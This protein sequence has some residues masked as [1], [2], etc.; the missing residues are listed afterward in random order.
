[1]RRPV[2]PE[3]MEQ[4]SRVP[5]RKP[6]KRLTEHAY[7]SS[8]EANTLDV[9]FGFQNFFRIFSRQHSTNVGILPTQLPVGRP[10]RQNSANGSGFK[11]RLIT[12][13]RRPHSREPARIASNNSQ[14]FGPGLLSIVFGFL[15]L[16]IFFPLAFHIDRPV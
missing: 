5:S 2:V 10:I 1:M 9:H 15:F 6:R 7:N 3:R 14:E 12:R 16:Y 11:E 4:F 13:A 8:E